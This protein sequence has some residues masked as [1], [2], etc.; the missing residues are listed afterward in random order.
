M[1]YW[2][3]GDKE[4]QSSLGFEKKSDQQQIPDKEALN[5]YLL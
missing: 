5:H 3:E 4:R 1:Y 2:L